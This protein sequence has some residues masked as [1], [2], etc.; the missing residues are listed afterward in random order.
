MVKQSERVAEQ[1]VIIN[2]GQEDTHENIMPVSEVQRY[3]RPMNKCSNCDRKHGPNRRCYA[4]KAKCYDCQ[5][6]GHF[7]KCCP[8]RGTPNNR[9]VDAATAVPDQGTFYYNNA[10]FIKLQLNRNVLNFKLDTGSQV[11]LISQSVFNKLDIPLRDTCITLTAVNGSTIK[12]MGVFTHNFVVNDFQH[13][14][15]VFV[16]KEACMPLLGINEII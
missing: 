8:A 14:A 15:D 1:Q 7:A 9:R 10:W 4:E 16:V 5:G 13:T 11:T 3:R 12:P 6:I 2:P